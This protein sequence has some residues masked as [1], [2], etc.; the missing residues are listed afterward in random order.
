MDLG[1]IT[2]G[3]CTKVHEQRNSDFENN[4]KEKSFH[5]NH[6]KIYTSVFV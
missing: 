6:S 3:D 1:F 4:H 2:K 5:M